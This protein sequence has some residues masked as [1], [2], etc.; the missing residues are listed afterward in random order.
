MSRGTPWSWSPV[1]LRSSRPSTLAGLIEAH[2][3][4]EPLVTL[5]TTHMPD[6]TGYGRIVRDDAGE[7]VGIVEER[8]ADDEQRRIDEV[9]VSTY[10]FAGGELVRALNRGGVR[11]TTRVRCISP[12]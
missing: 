12:M 1:T 9:G 7:V 5:L 11:P 2:A 8:D 4:A 10:A 6:P 3:V